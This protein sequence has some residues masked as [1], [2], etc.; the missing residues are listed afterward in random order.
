MRSFSLGSSICCVAR[1][2]DRAGLPDGGAGKGV[3][4]DESH[5]SGAAARRRPLKASRTPEEPGIDAMRDNIVEAAKLAAHFDNVLDMK[6]ALARPMA[7]AAS[8]PERWAVRPDRR[9]RIRR[10]APS[11]MLRRLTPS[12]QADLEHAAGAKGAKGLRTKRRT[13]RAQ[14][15]ACGRG[16][17]RI[18]H[19]IVGVRH[20]WLPILGKVDGLSYPVPA[21]PAIAAGNSAIRRCPRPRRQAGGQTTWKGW[22]ARRA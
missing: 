1:A 4:A 19:E 3:V 12:P 22:W 16:N 5:A 21:N 15:D 9:R 2:A 20:R 7:S 14:P 18:T 13:R 8:G 10:P 17:I 11:A 6:A